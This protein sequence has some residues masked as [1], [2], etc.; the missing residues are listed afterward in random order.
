[1][2]I[3]IKYSFEADILLRTLGEWYD[4]FQ[5]SHVRTLL[6]PVPHAASEVMEL[7]S[8][9][10]HSH[11]NNTCSLSSAHLLSILDHQQRYHPYLRGLNGSVYMETGM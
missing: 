11:P 6:I 4:V 7:T 1:M 3:F 2:L 5:Q 9:H 10:T 8:E